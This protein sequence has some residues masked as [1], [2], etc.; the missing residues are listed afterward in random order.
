MR[1]KIRIYR[2]KEADLFALFEA[3]GPSLT[4]KIFKEV[5]GC[6]LEGTAFDIQIPN[7]VPLTSKFAL[8]NPVFDVTINPKYE[9][10]IQSLPE[11]S[12]SDFMKALVRYYT[13]PQVVTRFGLAGTLTVSNTPVSQMQQTTSTSAKNAPA[14]QSTPAP[15]TPAP[16]KTAPQAEPTNDASDNVAPD[17]AGLTALFANIRQ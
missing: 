8:N 11:R 3:A 1:I 14:V 2:D 16:A 4:R 10:A 17:I 13:F 15:I 6:Y 12:R 9:S 7:P 5:L